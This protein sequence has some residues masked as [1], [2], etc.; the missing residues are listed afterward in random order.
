GREGWERVAALGP[1]PSSAEVP[2][3]AWR[4]A[5]A[6]ATGP[7]GFPTILLLE[8]LEFEGAHLDIWIERAG[9]YERI[10]E[11]YYWGC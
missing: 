7:S 1:T 6:F 8:A 11:G 4:P 2:T 3:P 9:R 10:Y 5:G